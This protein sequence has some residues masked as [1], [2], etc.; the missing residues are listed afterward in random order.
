MNEIELENFEDYYKEKINSIYSKI[1]KSV[2]KL[3]TDLEAN[4]VDIRSSIDHFEEASGGSLGDKPLRS[5]KFFVD[6]I[7]KE[8]DEISI[9]RENDVYHDN[10]I[11]LSTS[12]KKLFTTINETAR[13]ALPKFQKE[14]QPQ[15][16]ELNYLTRKLQKKLTIF[17]EFLRK[18]YGDVKKAEEL[19]HKL[20]K[21]FSLKDNIENAKKDLT[22]YEKELEDRKKNQEE[23]NQKLLE[24]EKNQLFQ[25]IK[26]QRDALFKLKI[27]INDELSFKKALKK[28]KVGVEKNKIS[29]PGIDPNYLRD[30]LKN[31]TRVLASDTTDLQKFRSLLVK[32]RHALEE[33]KLN[34]KSDKKDKTIEHINKIFEEKELHENIEKLKELQVNIKSL[35]NKIENQGLSGMS[36]DIKNQIS[37]NTVKLEHLE[38]DLNKKNNDY[39]RYLA[40]LKEQREDFQTLVKK[41]IGD[42]IKINI[43]FTF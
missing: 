18:K 30:F 36:E 26:E 29:V 35:K 34:L 24:L 38:N 15:I 27:E 3:I 13:K 28:L 17:N 16:K 23:L 10:L 2:S 12:I 33:N 5:L 14:V 11:E 1:K 31:P 21:I 43:S 42:D 37:L 22:E 4:L 9:P 19:I 20:P 40:S 41:T 25:E 8:I 6:R 39:T 32:L 7:N